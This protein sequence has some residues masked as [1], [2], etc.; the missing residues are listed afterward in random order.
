MIFIFWL[1]GDLDFSP[2]VNP[3]PL[4]NWYDHLQIHDPVLEA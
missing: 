4:M 2:T 3:T 1:I